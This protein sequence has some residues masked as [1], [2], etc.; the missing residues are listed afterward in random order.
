MIIKSAKIQT[1]ATD[2][3]FYPDDNLP[4]IALAG[5]SNVGKS[6][7]IN[8]LLNRKSLASVSGTPGKT[9]TIN[10]FII[11]ESFY[12]VDLPGYGYAK[13]SK[14]E[15]ESWGKTMELYFSKSKN[16][17]H[18]FLLLDIRH[19]PKASDKQM[20]DYCKYYNIPVDIIATKSDKISRGAY[21]K[22]FSLMKKYL[23][24]KDEIK[25]FP[26]SSLN[27]NGIE[28]LSNYMETVIFT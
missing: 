14:Y 19:E 23:Q 9:R 11:N 8:S 16:L 13:L 25:I 26:I 20:Y 28:D 15:Q 6:S 24:I 3:K 27:K 1:S 12:L 2:P 22:S 18:V 17:K 5:R 7:L 4:C 21:Q 10:F